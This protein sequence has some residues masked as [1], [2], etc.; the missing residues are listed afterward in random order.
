MRWNRSTALHGAVTTGQN[1]IV[2]Y[3]VDHGARLDARNKLGWTPL[4][5]AE[6]GQF[7]AT[8]KEFPEAVTLL[9][10]LMRERGMDPDEYSKAGAV[11]TRVQRF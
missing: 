5:V 3:L 8:V 10:K 6:G 1:S 7:G 9:Q 2:Q 4:M 11:K